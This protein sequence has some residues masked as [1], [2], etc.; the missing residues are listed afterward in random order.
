MTQVSEH[1]KPFLSIEMLVARLKERGLSTNDKT[2]IILLQEGYYSIINGY[3][4]PFLDAEQS[5]KAGDDR[6]RKG[7]SFDDLHALYSFDRALRELTFHH[8]IRI[9]SMVKTI[10]AHVF[11]F[12]HPNYDDYLK[13]ENFCSEHEYEEFGLNRHSENLEKL[14]C[15]LYKKAKN[16]RREPIEHYRLTYGGVPLWVLDID[17]TFGNIQHFYNLMKPNERLS[18][19]K[20]I[21]RATGRTADKKL[22][23]F[24]PKEARTSLDTLV[25]M[26]NMCAH[27]ERLYCARIGGRRNDSYSSATKRMERFMTREDYSDFLSGIQ[28]LKHEYATGNPQLEGVLSTIA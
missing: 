8:L 23:Y 10:C 16:S 2:E 5:K 18:V 22:G 24:D 14:T 20:F 21:A 1:K 3:K 19:C 27:D 4:E 7:T 17:L 25:Q 11:S 28:A 12:H 9:E 15:L 26:R 6:Y 13:N